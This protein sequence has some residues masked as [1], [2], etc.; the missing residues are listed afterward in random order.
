MINSNGQRRSPL[1]VHVYVRWK[2]PFHRTFYKYRSNIIELPLDFGQS[3]PGLNIPQS[4]EKQRSVKN[5][6]ILTSSLFSIVSTSLCT[7]QSAFTHTLLIV[8]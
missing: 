5:T 6:I 3:L 7:H 2:S 1:L 8:I 4:R